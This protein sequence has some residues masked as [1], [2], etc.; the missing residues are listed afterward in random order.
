[1]PQRKHRNT[2]EQFLQAIPDRELRMRLQPERF[3]NIHGALQT[4][5]R[6]EGIFQADRQRYGYKNVAYV[7]EDD[8]ESS[9]EEDSEGRLCTMLVKTAGPFSQKVLGVPSHSRGTREILHVPEITIK[10]SLGGKHPGGKA[11]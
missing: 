7:A 4:V 8:F 5:V 2:L 10:T 11:S 1:M 3:D 6:L 9:G